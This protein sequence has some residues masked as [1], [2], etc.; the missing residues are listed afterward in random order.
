MM[1][2]APAAVSIVVVVVVVVAFVS[3]PPSDTIN[4][5]GHGESQTLP[6]GSK[7]PVSHGHSTLVIAL[8]QER[9]QRCCLLAWDCVAKGMLSI[10]SST[11]NLLTV[12]CERRKSQ[13]EQLA[14][15]GVSLMNSPKT[16][17]L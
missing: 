1:S 6:G 14:V 5:L 4:E 12:L 16:Q 11:P 10:A 3:A 9:I 2:F 13:S 7:Q 15:C 8:L 17:H